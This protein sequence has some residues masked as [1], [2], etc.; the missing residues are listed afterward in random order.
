MEHLHT[1]LIPMHELEGCQAC[2]VKAHEKIEC[3]VQMMALAAG[4]VTPLR[5]RGE[6]DG[7]EG[8]SGDDQQERGETWEVTEP[9]GGTAAGTALCCISVCSLCAFAVDTCARGLSYPHV[10]TALSAK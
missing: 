1:D 3:L 7:Q 9:L 10:K 4:P 6:G 5:E 8:P 2:V